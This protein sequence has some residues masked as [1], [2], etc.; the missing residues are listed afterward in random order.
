MLSRVPEKLTIADILRYTVIHMKGDLQPTQ[1]G[2]GRVRRVLREELAGLLLRWRVVQ[3][4]QSLI[5]S[6]TGLRLRPCLYRLAGVRIGRGTVLSGRI[7]ICGSGRPD[8]RLHIGRNCYLNERVT[9]NLGGDVFLD[10]GVSVGMEC[11]FLTVTHAIGGPDFRAGNLQSRDVRV[12]RG[13]WLGARVTLL[14]GVTVGA[15]AVIGAGAVVTRDIPPN[16]LAA[17]VPARVVRSLETL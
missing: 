9:F 14:P 8:Q 15:G 7:H 6:G 10:E 11:L 3:A 1:S 16:I 12:G 4:L 2:L 17:G 13:A 5:P